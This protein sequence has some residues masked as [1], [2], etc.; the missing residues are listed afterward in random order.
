MTGKRCGRA[1]NDLREESS[2]IKKGHRYGYEI[3]QGEK[4]RMGF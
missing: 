4:R 2:A 3:C 1:Q